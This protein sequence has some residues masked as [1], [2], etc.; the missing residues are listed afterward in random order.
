M[1]RRLP[2]WIVLVALG[3]GGLLTAVR[4]LPE[5]LDLVRDEIAMDRGE[6]L[7]AAERLAELYDLRPASAPDDRRAAAS[8]GEENPGARSFVE[9]EQGGSEVFESLVE[10]G[11]YV[12]SRWTV[13][14]FAPD[15]VAESW[16][17]FTPAGR[18]LGFGVTLSDEDPG[19]GNLE[20]GAAEVLARATATEWDVDLTEF[21]LVE[22]SSDEAPSGRIDHRFTFRRNGVDLGEGEVRLRV[23]VAGD[24]AAGVYHF[25]EVPESFQ[26]RYQEIRTGNDGIALAASALFLVLFVGVAGGGGVL[27][28]A[29]EGWLEV[30]PALALGAAV[31]F[32]LTLNG[33]NTLPL[34]WMAYDTSLRESG[35]VAQLVGSALLIGLVAAPFLGAVYMA[36]E[37]MGRR[38][39][40]GHLQQWR[41]WS[42]DVARSDPA[43][44][45][46][47][48]GYV[49]AGLH[50]GYVTLFSLGTSRLEGWW[51]PPSNVIQ[52]DLI[53]TVQ[54]WVLAVATNLFAATWEESVFRAMPLAGA[55]LL[56][57]RFGRRGLWVGVALVLQAVVF[58][59][60]HA[61]YPQQPAYARVV[62]L[63]GPALVWGAVYL[64]FGL[65][66]TIFAH[67]LYNLYLSS[68]PLF[69]MSSP[70]IWVD[71][72]AV[73]AVASVPLVV[74]LVARWRH[75]AL[76]EAPAHARNGA[77][78]PPAGVAAAAADPPP[79]VEEPGPDRPGAP[80]LNVPVPRG[81]LLPLGLGL[82][83]A[84]WIVAPGSGLPPASAT[85]AE[86]VAAA[87]AEMRSRGFDPDAW[88]VLADFTTVTGG[89]QQWVFE[90]YGAE[91]HRGLLGTWI[92]SPHWQVR[93]VAFE[94]P[95][96]DRAEEFAVA[97]GGDGV[98]TGFRHTLPEGREG[99]SLDEAAARAVALEALVARGH[100]PAAFDEVAA[101][102]SA[103][104]ARL[105]WTFGFRAREVL[106]D[107]L[108]E[109][110]VNITVSGDEV[111][112]IRTVVEP[113]ESWVRE[114]AALL[115]RVLA[116]AIPVVLLVLAGGSFLV[117]AGVRLWTRKALHLPTLGAVAGVAAALLTTL[118]LNGVPESMAGFVPALGWSIQVGGLVFAGLFFV[119][120]GAG[121]LGVTAAV[122]RAWLP[123]R[124]WRSYPVGLGV[125]ATGAAVL[126][127]ALV[128]RFLPDPSPP[129]RVFEGID[130]AVPL[131]APLAGGLL[132]FVGGSVVLTFL[133]AFYRRAGT[134]NRMRT[135]FE[136]G[137][138]LVAGSVLAVG[139][140][141]GEVSAIVAAGLVAMGI[142]VYGWLYANHPLIAVE[143]AGA[144]ALA[145]LVATAVDP[146]YP[147]QAVGA[148]VGAALVAAT[149]V[150][151][152]RRIQGSE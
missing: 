55:A 97:V 113:P 8:Y 57:A 100:D 56:G 133:G 84:A 6:A 46:T 71:R 83:V 63:L 34:A 48:A 70:G 98:V 19:G 59:A 78:V 44:G 45:L 136:V 64:R 37:S 15:S 2:F 86:A 50:L 91:V 143:A 121:A 68:I 41:F 25:I 147:G 134:S 141:E 130:Y 114:Q 79:P 127:A 28:L 51:S 33:L 21:E 26:L 39:F 135:A 101:D 104:P 124:T 5:A 62:E 54:P 92:P 145:S 12:P 80:P 42:R 85:R 149:T 152:W 82:L 7:V 9:L 111:T 65:V 60:G 108:G 88:R 4:L 116:L 27:V 94:G 132:E 49:I 13:R 150:L 93:F 144:G 129:T 66:P 107:T 137:V 151:V 89:G 117:V 61:N 142:H 96:E 77:W 122:T 72:G 24:R 120:A 1:T 36:A 20:P 103:R 32:G 123:R 131:L 30:R 125:A 22:S 58:A 47:L 128:A 109:A 81:V 53:A 29:R 69:Q 16:I 126:I 3:I 23:D 118:F 110:R 146:S 102:Q 119:T 73:L 35:F 140:G 52:P 11:A 139:W 10:S 90:E 115:N 76:E 43:L 106:P 75:G 148:A 38:A 67:F 31:G 17:E 99:P 95:A 14:L 18:P 40:P 105:D 112:A 138:A 87:E 74:V